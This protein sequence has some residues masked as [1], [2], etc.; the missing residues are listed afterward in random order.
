MP[1]IGSV[2]RAKMKCELWVEEKMGGK[3]WLTM[4]QDRWAQ[5]RLNIGMLGR[6]IDK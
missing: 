4:P 5:S 3:T 2:V 1:N 6:Y